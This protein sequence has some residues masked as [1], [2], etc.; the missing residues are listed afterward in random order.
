MSGN[1]T[2][3]NKSLDNK[4][5]QKDQDKRSELERKID[6]IN[7]S[8]DK[9]ITASKKHKRGKDGKAAPKS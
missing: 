3:E 4:N 8:S 6:D 5:R 2:H 9:D 1:E 7:N